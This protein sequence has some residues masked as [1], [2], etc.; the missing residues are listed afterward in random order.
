[1]LASRLTAAATIGQRTC[2][3]CEG[4]KMAGIDLTASL[5]HKEASGDIGGDTDVGLEV[6]GGMGKANT[7]DVK[8]R[9]FAVGIPLAVSLLQPEGAL[10]TLFLQPSVAYGT[11]TTSGVDQG[12]PR[13][14]I[15][16]GLGYTF[17]FGLGVHAAAHRVAIE[18]SPTQFGVGMSW[19]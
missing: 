18:D 16:A 11:L 15:S 5:L 19:R 6:S 4:L 14:L 10:L 3:T 7:S 13:F 2:Q 8:A 17:A 1:K 9:S 12:A